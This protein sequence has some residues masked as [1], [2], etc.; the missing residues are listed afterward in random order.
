MRVELLFY[1]IVVTG[2]AMCLALQRP[3]PA[4]SPCQGL[5]MADCGGLR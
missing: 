3:A 4:V 2:L 1:A 5:V